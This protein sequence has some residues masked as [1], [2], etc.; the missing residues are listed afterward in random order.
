MG[1]GS[2]M[3]WGNTQ[4][5]HVAPLVYNLLEQGSGKTNR[6]SVGGG[7]A[8]NPAHFHPARVS[9]TPPPE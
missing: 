5:V 4:I 1:A 7:G 9:P 2:R 8:E 3:V 6:N